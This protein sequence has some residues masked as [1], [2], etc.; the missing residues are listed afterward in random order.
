MNLFRLL[1]AAPGAVALIAL[2]CSS[3]PTDVPLGASA[4]VSGAGASAARVV[5]P[6]RPLAGTGPSTPA[7]VVASLSALSAR[8]GD[9][10]PLKAGPPPA[11]IRPTSRWDLAT[12]GVASSGVQTVFGF[13]DASDQDVSGAASATNAVTVLEEIKIRDLAGS[14]LNHVNIYNFFCSGEPAFSEC[15]TGGFI[16][17]PRV[18]YD[19]G[20]DRWVISGM[21]VFSSLPDHDVLAVSQT[22]DP[23]A[24]WYLY[25]FPA[26]GTPD[27]PDTTDGSDQPHLGFSDQWIV[28]TALCSPG[29]KSLTVFDKAKLYAGD[30]LAINTNYFK[31][32]DSIENNNNNRDNPVSTYAALPDH[33]EYLT[34]TT[35]T[36][37]AN[38]FAQVVYSY[39]EGPADAPI[40]FPSAFT[41]TSTFR[42]SFA[43]SSTD[44]GKFGYC[45]DAPGCTDCIGSLTLGWSHSSGVYA[46]ANGQPVILSTVAL[47]DPAFAR[48]GQVIATSF[49]LST[50]RSSW[51]RVPPTGAGDGL[52]GSEI[53]MPAVPSGA[54]NVALITYDETSP[55]F[56]PGA[57]I[58]QW[59]LDANVIAGTTVLREGDFT[60]TQG[61]FEATRFID[62]LDSTTPIPGSQDVFVGA[63]I[64]HDSSAIQPGGN[65]NRGVYYAVV[66]PPAVACVTASQAGTFYDSAFGT[67]SGAFAAEF[68]A[69]PSAA[70]INAIVG[71]SSGAQTAYTG[72]AALVRFNPSG[73]IDAR[74]GGAYQARAPIAYAAGTTYHF[75]LLV[76]VPAHTY[77]VYVTPPGGVELTVATGFAFRTEQQGV[78]SLDSWGADV[79]A[80]NPGSLSVCG[81]AVQPCLAARAGAGFV[82][83]PMVNETG[84]FGVQF[85]ATPSV[86]PTNSVIAL[87]NGPQTGYTGF[88]SLVR[89]SPSGHVDARNGPAYQAAT[90][91]PYSAGSTYHF[92]LVVN[93]AAHTYSIFVTPPG[94]PEQTIG[95]SYAF[96]TE[97]AGVTSLNDWGVETES[98]T[99][100][101]CGFA[102]E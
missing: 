50:S 97:Q 26:C 91:V 37:D 102:N 64:A 62:F 22:S 71:L 59:N 4:D 94:G 82:D 45:A 27:Q 14:V 42:T 69:T 80:S 17:D 74:N 23:T 20:A 2:G 25:E 29:I 31:F 3:A 32:V 93:V 9:T 35:T 10:L 46:L 90:T 70:P 24:G 77:S 54:S 11:G 68:D 30:P 66:A 47:G 79:N 40:Y 44:C 18:V 100:T 52:L 41:A 99:T 55:T 48:S 19:P 56:F 67:Q 8:E 1:V 88:A 43:N 6:V 28:T 72:F 34:A 63:E 92:R 95:L 61:S 75:R 15:T 57:K 51:V 7:R 84:T 101:V 38:Q 86:S 78:M 73:D 53:T 36:P 58:A 39:L 87:S 89:F 65:A 21:W 5:R 83:T 96:R 81:F 85:D 12:S 16:G 33:R 76:D 49:N 13:F 60:P 98:G